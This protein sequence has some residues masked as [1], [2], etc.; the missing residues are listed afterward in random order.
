MS[1]PA[2]KLGADRDAKTFGDL[3]LQT[4]RRSHRQLITPLMKEKNCSGINCKELAQPIQ[5]YVKQV[6]EG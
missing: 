1:N 6:V 4:F 2:G 5:E 3:L